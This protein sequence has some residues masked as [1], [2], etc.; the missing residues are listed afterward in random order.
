MVIF[1]VIIG[2]MAGIALA[3][4]LYVKKHGTSRASRC[5][6]PNEHWDDTSASEELND[7]DGGADGD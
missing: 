2:L 1:L 7:F 5:N 3:S 4:Y 6:D